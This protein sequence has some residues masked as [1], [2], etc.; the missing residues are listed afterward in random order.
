LEEQSR[1]EIKGE[2]RYGI[3]RVISVDGLE[4]TFLLLPGHPEAKE[5]QL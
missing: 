1:D 4:H 2:N 3:Y 5:N